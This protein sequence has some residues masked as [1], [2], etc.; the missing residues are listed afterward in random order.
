MTAGEALRDA[1]ARIDRRDAEYLLATLLGVGRAALIAHD[2]RILPDAL[3]QRFA[4][5]VAARA[6]G[7]PVAQLTGLREFYGRSFLV[8]EH[9]LIPR[10][11]TEI[12]VEQA[13]ARCS[14]QNP[15]ERRADKRMLDLGTGSGAIAVTLALE[16]RP[17]A[18]VTA[19]D[20]STAALAVARHNADTLGAR[21]HLLESDWYG[22]LAGETF[23]VIVANPPYV[24]RDDPHLQQ[25][26][27]RFEPRA[28]L[29]DD[30]A[31]GMG[32]IRTIL[33][34]AT[35]HLV[36][37]GWILIEHGYDQAASCRDA[38]QR[39]GLCF[40]ES[41]ADLA[42]IPRVAVGRRQD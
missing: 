9:V 35:A 24:A 22:A 31:D 19:V 25:G 1:A 41:V 7:R 30:S 18:V 3:A 28:A 2:E 14:G 29:T 6:R 34:G 10:P 36:R 27:L 23:D 42:G 8:D 15:L 13:L 5:Q 4:K 17:P 38:M 39:A 26:D 20:R 37:G 33:A 12:L 16:T 40:V 21:I 32:A 11:E